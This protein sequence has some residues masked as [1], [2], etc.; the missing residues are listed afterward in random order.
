MRN[1]SLPSDMD[2][3]VAAS[4]PSATT[5]SVTTTRFQAFRQQHRGKPL[6][7]ALYLLALAALLLGYG[8]MFFYLAPDRSYE[9]IATWNAAVEYRAQQIHAE[10]VE[11]K[12][13]RRVKREEEKTAATTNSN[14]D[15]NQFLTFMLMYWA[16]Q[17]L[18][19]HCLRHERSALGNNT[20]EVM[21]R[22]TGQRAGS[23]AR[24]DSINND[25]RRLVDPWPLL[26]ERRN[27][28]VEALQLLRAA[29]E[30]SREL[31]AQRPR[32]ATAEQIEACPVR[33]VAADDDMFLSR[34]ERHVPQCDICLDRYRAGDTIRTIPCF[35]SFHTGCIDVWL[36]QRAACPVCVHPV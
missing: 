33:V 1:S 11:Q 8:Y 6:K 32:G 7:Q 25:Q 18:L 12:R 2:A 15:L 36:G 9:N 31:E 4:N 27:L 22:R 14:H 16:C 30:P 24:T 20:Q 29:E 23:L 3:E 5:A 17:N 26:F 34:E 19:R 21:R 28:D 10:Q 13:L 35:H